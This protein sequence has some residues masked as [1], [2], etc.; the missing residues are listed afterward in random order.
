MPCDYPLDNEYILEINL[1]KAKRLQHCFNQFLQSVWLKMDFGK[2]KGMYLL[3]VSIVFNAKAYSKFHV[4]TVIQYT[5]PKM[6]T[7]C[8]DASCSLTSKAQIL[9]HATRFDLK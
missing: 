5:A 8:I 3:D 4:Q 2:T 1:T 6:F 9:F 7:E